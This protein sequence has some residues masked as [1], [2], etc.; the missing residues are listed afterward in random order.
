M[1]VMGNEFPSFRGAAER[2]EGTRR[3]KRENASR[4]R[5]A[6]RE[7]V[8]EKRREQ[9]VDHTRTRATH[10]TTRTRVCTYSQNTHTHNRRMNVTEADRVHIVMR[11]YPSPLHYRTVRDSS[12]ALPRACS[13]ARNDRGGVY[14]SVTRAS[15][16]PFSWRSLIYTY[17]YIHIRE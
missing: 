17:I 8:V 13:T 4:L 9:E 11:R 6:I 2:N 14:T 5:A 16:V 7:K 10:T 3:R 12:N 1:I 15:L